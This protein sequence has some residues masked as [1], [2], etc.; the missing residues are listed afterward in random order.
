MGPMPD[1][2]VLA[3]VPHQ[4]GPAKTWKTK[5]MKHCDV[6]RSGCSTSSR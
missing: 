3:P 5:P 4:V 6:T 2:D 1:N